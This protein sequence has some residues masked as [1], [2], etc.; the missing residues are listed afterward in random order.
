M[1]LND[2]L[3]NNKWIQEKNQEETNKKKKKIPRDNENE[4]AVIQNIRHGKRSS[5]QEVYSNT[6]KISNKQ[7][8][9]TRT[10]KSRKNKQT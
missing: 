1:K 5:K 7:H 8:K 3:L 2:M 4:N 6:R 10:G 9:L